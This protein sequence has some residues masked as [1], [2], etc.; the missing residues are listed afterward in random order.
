MS[1]QNSA[2]QDGVQNSIENSIQN[3]I[4]SGGSNDGLNSGEGRCRGEARLVIKPTRSAVEFG[5]ANDAVMRALMAVHH[6]NRQGSADDY[7]AV[8]LPGMG[9]GRTGM[10]PGMQVDLFGSDASLN[11]LLGLEGM[12]ALKRR[13]MIEA[14]VIGEVRVDAGMTG[15][16]Y[17]RD[18]ASERHTPGWVRRTL[19]RALRRDKPLGKAVTPRRHDRATL[20]LCYGDKVLNVREQMGEI[21]A[22]PILVS[23]YGFSAAGA[24][25]FL[26]VSPA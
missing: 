26:P 25:A 16:A 5:A 20:P 14:P 24:L 8:A 18:R 17:V 2:I 3:G 13:G 11:A 7:I 23:T 21:V 6:A 9:A 15:A 19:A 22:G 4:P 12:I 1:S 10:Q